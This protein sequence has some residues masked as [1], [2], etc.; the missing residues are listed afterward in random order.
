MLHYFDK[1]CLTLNK[2]L[3]ELENPESPSRF[4]WMHS[5]SSYSPFSSS[6]SFPCLSLVGCCSV[7][8]CHKWSTAAIYSNSGTVLSINYSTSQGDLTSTSRRRGWHKSVSRALS[9]R[10]WKASDEFLQSS[11]ESRTFSAC[12]FAAFLGLSTGLQ[13]MEKSDNVL[14]WLLSSCYGDQHWTSR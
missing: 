10:E 5:F 3:G 11:T 7:P 9:N 4:I 14:S 1:G 8:A 12:T 2:N 6:S 13:P